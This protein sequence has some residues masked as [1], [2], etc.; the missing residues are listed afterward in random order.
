MRDLSLCRRDFEKEGQRLEALDPRFQHITDLVDEGKYTQAANEV[1]SLLG[2]NLYDVRLLGYYVFTAFHEDGLTRLAE[3][4]DTLAELL[5][6][7]WDGLPAGDK[8]AVL[9]N[10]SFT[11][12][13]QTLVDALK[14]HQAKKDERW[15][16]WLKPLTEAHVTEATEKG[17]ALLGLLP[18]PTY[19]ASAEVLAQGVQWLRDLKAQLAAASRAQK[20]QEAAQA[21]A[22]P[23]SAPTAPSASTFM[24]LGQLVQLRGSAHFV[25]LNNKLKAF[26]LL[27]ERKDFA[28]A[29]LVSDDILAALSDFDPRRYFPDLFAN[30]GALLNKHVGDI[31][32]HWEHK[33]STEWKMLAQFYQV[34]LENFVGRK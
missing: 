25:E 27:V 4:F 18:E 13:F 22:A 21:S 11:W 34:D 1:A 5:R 14:Y 15:A 10:K 7:N 23:A 17:Q 29:A 12:L 28:K 24:L 2:E 26:E 9:A 31:Q 3:M 19:H 20:A 32:A 30:F 6:R 16:G 33:D 8:R